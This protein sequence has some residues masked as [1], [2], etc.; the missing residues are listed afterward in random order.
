[1]GKNDNTPYD[2]VFKTMVTDLPRITLKLINEMFRDTM[3]EKYTGNEPVEQ[4]SNEVYLD[5]QDGEQG[6]RITDARIRVIGRSGVKQ[7]HIEC[8]STPDGSMIVRMFEYD[9]QI[10]LQD[11]DN[12]GQELTVNF[13]ESG[14]LYLRHNKTTP[15]RMMIN[16]NTP[17]GSV[18]YAVPVMKLGYYSVDDIIKK[19]LYFLIPFYLFRFERLIR[20]ERK[21]GTIE[22]TRIEHIRCDYQK[23]R[24]YLEEACISGIINEYE[25]CTIF[26]MS[27]KVLEN[28]SEGSETIK[29]EVGS[30][31]GGKIL[32]YEAKDIL[33]QG[34]SQGITQGKIEEKAE[35]IERVTRN[36][37][38]MDPTLT[39]D[40]AREKA[41]MILK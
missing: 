23:L 21:Q 24:K 11:S 2:D 35:T 41:L 13:P 16:I 37:M 33:N 7:Y 39:A 25:K 31:M 3:S 34:I 8:Q 20:I 9:S 36:Y 18:S 22:K 40:E 17:G 30:I 12:T 28:L 1:M 27:K 38:E 5:G 19:D 4:L 10:A 14:I 15:D 26:D 32:D 6:K 29:K